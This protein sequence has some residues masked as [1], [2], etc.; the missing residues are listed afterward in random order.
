MTTKYLLF[1]ML[2]LFMINSVKPIKVLWTYHSATAML[3]DDSIDDG[4][5][6]VVS[7]SE[8]LVVRQRELSLQ[9]SDGVIGASHRLNYQPDKM[10]GYKAT[11]EEIVHVVITTHAG[12]QSSID[13]VAYYPYSY[14]H[15]RFFPFRRYTPPTT[16]FVASVRITHNEQM[17][18]YAVYLNN[19]YLTHYDVIEDYERGSDRLPQDCSN[20]N[21]RLIPVNET[22][23]GVILKCDSGNAYLYDPYIRNFVPLPPGIQHIATSKHGDLMLACQAAKGLYQDLMAVIN[24]ATDQANSSALLLVKGGFAT[25]KNP[26]WITDVAVV[27]VN[28][29]S[30][31]EVGYFIRNNELLYF[32]LTELD[33]IE[34]KSSSCPPDIT[35]TAVRGT[36]NS[37]I[38]IE[39]IFSNGTSVIVVAETESGNPNVDVMITTEPNN[40]RLNDSDPES[41]T[42]TTPSPPSHTT[43]NNDNANEPPTRPCPADK[44]L[45]TNENNDQGDSESSGS[46]SDGFGSK[47]TTCVAFIG[48]VIITL[49]IF[50]AVILLYRFCKTVR[51]LKINDEENPGEHSNSRYWNGHKNC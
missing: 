21:T 22:N 37:S 1:V 18:V 12:E 3:S 14:D 8:V 4:I 44:P 47:G 23:G 41:N 13:E 19:G 51:K 6:T 20:N 11:E 30:Q 24:M 35:L 29:T 5:F 48:G 2:V 32:E 42:T 27:V 45:P 49:T 15:Q 46:H 26:I 10:Y 17:S 38:A 40:S 34:V 50:F 9:N 39:G 33:E 28:K 31:L 25:S 16:D 43:P 36:Y 7:G